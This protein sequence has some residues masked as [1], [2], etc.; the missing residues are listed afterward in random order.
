MGDPMARDI[1]SPRDP[2]IWMGKHMIKEA[3]QGAGP[4]RTP[5]KACMQANGQHFW[6]RRAFL[7]EL[8]KA[9]TQMDEKIIARAIGSR[10]AEFQVIGIQGIRND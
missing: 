4:A 8:I 2:N 7:I 1:D 5:D 10:C 3:G 9:V 6:F